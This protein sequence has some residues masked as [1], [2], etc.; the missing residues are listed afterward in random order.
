[1]P[2]VGGHAPKL[3]QKFAVGGLLWLITAF[4]L[5][6]FLI[7]PLVAI[8][9]SAAWPPAAQLIT[10]G[11][12]LVLLFFN[13]LYVPVTIALAYYVFKPYLHTVRLSTK[14]LIGL[15]R[16]PRIRDA[17]PVL[18][19]YVVYYILALIAFV[20]LSLIV[21]QST[22]DQA[23]NLGISA[24]DTAAEYIL[25]FIML[26]ILPPVFEEILFRGYAY[27]T[28]RTGFAPVASALVTSVLFGMAHGQLNLFIDTFILSLALCYLRERTGAIW[29]GMLLHAL[30]NLVAFIALYILNLG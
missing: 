19:A 9:L 13:F 14:K 16:P 17:Y 1:M 21:P 18:P 3:S 5:A 11:N 10:G 15:A 30:K 8:A 23:Q 2:A 26:V 12:L 22:L 6:N 28:L 27:G 25:T 7:V 29:A 20:L 24:P 4:L